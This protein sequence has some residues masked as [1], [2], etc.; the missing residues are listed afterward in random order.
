MYDI[1]LALPV[2]IICLITAGIFAMIYIYAMTYFSTQI[3][4]CV[5]IGIN[6][7]MICFILMFVSVGGPALIGALI[8][9]IFL[10]AFDAC[11]YCKWSEVKIAIAIIEATAEFFIVTKRINFVSM[12]Y[13]FVSAVWSILWSAC[14]LVQ[15][16]SQGIIWEGKDTPTHQERS[17]YKGEDDLMSKII[18]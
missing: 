12:F 14:L 4:Y 10:I 15:L 9:L 7:M 8:T 18:P 6:L 2:F 16:S 3:A 13:F 17:L 11:L 1:L 5:I